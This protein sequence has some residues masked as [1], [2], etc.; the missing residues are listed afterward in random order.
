MDRRKFIVN[1]GRATCAL[2]L[3]GVAYRVAGKHLTAGET[4]PTSRFVWAIDPEKCN[5]CGICETAC[6]RTP[7]AVKAVNDQKKCSFCVVCY[8]HISNK[9]I[10]SDKIMSEG[11]RVCKYDAVQRKNFSGTSDG[12]FVYSIDDKKCTACGLCV[13]N[14]NEKGTRSM[15]LI[16]RPDLCLACNS[17]NIAA[18][19]PQKAI[20]RVYIGPE[21][22]F[23]GEYDETYN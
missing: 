2:A 15:F 10:E 12:S 9:N 3:G 23:K 14:C 21:D 8:G 6:V 17:C 20:D 13:K 22:D 18:K 11:E 1:L 5:G 4:G 7:S 16:I 19:C